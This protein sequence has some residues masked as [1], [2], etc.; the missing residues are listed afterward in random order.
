MMRT[1][2]FKTTFYGLFLTTLF[3]TSSCQRDGDD[4]ADAQ[5]ISCTDIDADAV[6]ADRGLAIDYTLDCIVS[7]NAKLIIEP[8]VTILVKSGAG[9]I[10][11]NTGALVATG[12]T[13]NTIVIKSE[14]DVAGVW[15]GVYI[16][17]NNVLN[18]INHCTISN[19][20]SGSF[21][22]NS[23]KLANIR[24]AL[25]AKL[26][27]QNST[28]SKSAKDGL[29]ADGL[30]TDEQSPVTL[31]SG[32]TF[33]QNENYPISALGS[34]A[35][36]LDGTGSTYTGNTYN[37]IFLRGGRLFGAHTWAKLSVPYHIE[38][39]V[40]V[41]YSGDNGNLTIAPGTVVE[42]GGDAG[43][44]VGEY[45]PTSWMSIV[46][47]AANRITLTG[48]TALPGAWKGVA[49]ESTN[50]NNRVSYVDVSYG[51]S[52][53]YTGNGSQLGNIIAGAWSSGSF[54]IDNTTIANS[55]AYGIYVTMP[56]PSI[57][58]PGSVT[59]TNNA[60]GNYFEE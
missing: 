54:N 19:G 26:K 14:Q 28:I 3:F 48:E 23:S 13:A 58:V 20:G 4:V 38:S 1:Q 33:T 30:D 17:S 53:S 56:S 2:I 40:M 29:L 6:W 8:G 34:I 32:N 10:I 27:L 25:N 51:G 47:D 9:I 50:V 22:G 35:S 5:P 46:G 44:A 45:S 18:E 43:L 15:K 12:T 24:L 7:V 59:Y 37:K 41:G 57:T 31:F 16:K 11:E 42:F 36:K 55:A 39:V 52:S 21:D 49:F 60:S